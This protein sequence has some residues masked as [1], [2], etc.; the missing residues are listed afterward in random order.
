VTVGPLPVG[1]VGVGS[2]GFHHARL[3][4]A[5][6]C[7]HLVG[8]H[9][10][11]PERAEEVAR[12]CKTRAYGTLDSLLDAVHAVSVAV[13]ARAHH[14]VGLAALERGRHVLM[15]KPLA[16][17]VGEAT[18]LVAAAD[19]ARVVL[20]PG[21]VERFNPSLVAV[22]SSLGAPRRLRFR[23]LAPFRRRGADVSVVL[24]L[25]VHDLDLALWLDGGP[26][27][28][29]EA[30]AAAVLGDS[31]D[32]ATAR[33]TFAS[34][35]VA[36]FEASRVA[37]RVVRTLEA[38]TAGGSVVLDLAPAAHG[39]EPL[40]EEIAGFVRAVRGEAAPAVPARAGLAAVE[41]AW[42]VLAAA[43]ARSPASAA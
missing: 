31:A 21:H 19:R 32:V 3:Y 2:L 14:A 38:Q 22:K 8:V 16:A 33:V 41:L 4:A 27:T 28:G 1:V 29:V 42:R 39:A 9:D 37:D 12:E 24:D 10:S 11:S 15:E 7:V 25:M 20:Q 30:S 34:G 40:G 6:P 43:S 23:R 26:V 13:P 36:E 35:C 5:L 17:T 18:A